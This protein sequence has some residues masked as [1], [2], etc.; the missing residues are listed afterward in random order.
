MHLP[1]LNVFISTYLEILNS[2]FVWLSPPNAFTTHIYFTNTDR[3]TD[4]FFPSLCT[5]WLDEL[6]PPAQTLSR[7]S[8]AH[9][10]STC[11]LLR[12]KGTNTNTNVNTNTDVDVNTNTNTDVDVNTNTN[13]AP[14]LSQSPTLLQSCLSNL[15]SSQIWGTCTKFQ[16]DVWSK[17]QWNGTEDVVHGIF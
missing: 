13:T 12:F 15:L 11:F 5:D 14:T 8:V 9:T 2:R 4:V 17:N 6:A 3:N 10:S 7:C 1:V 16:L